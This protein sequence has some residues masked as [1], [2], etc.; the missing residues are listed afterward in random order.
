MSELAA[1]Q[2][3]RF[4]VE[5]VDDL[6][7]GLAANSYQIRQIDHAGNTILSLIVPSANLEPAV[8]GH[9]EL[10]IS[11]SPSGEVSIGG[12]SVA[13]VDRQRTTINIEDLIKQSI[14][15][16]MLEDEPDVAAQLRTLKKRL[17]A[18]LATVAEAISNL[19]P[20]STP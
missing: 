6:S 8:F 4:V 7:A 13:T 14:S 18:S 5:A 15:P 10:F 11:L 9:A 17:T 19:E 2:Q 20:K 12:V 16:Q 1:C 3:L